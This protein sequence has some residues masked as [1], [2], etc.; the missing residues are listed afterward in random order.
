MN[1]YFDALEIELRGAV[2]R[3]ARRRLRLSVSV[4]RPQG[5]GLA[6][7]VAVPVVVA[8]LAFGLL[9]HRS[10]PAVGPLSGG[11]APAPSTAAARAPVGLVLRG[12]GL[13]EVRFGA[14]RQQVVA[15]LR[16]RL[17]RPTALRLVGNCGVDQTVYWP[18]A[19]TRHGDPKRDEIVSVDLAHGRFVGYQVGG[20]FLG[21]RKAPPIHTFR[22]TAAR[23]LTTAR[24]LALNDRLRRAR[25]LYGRRLHLSNAQ[26]GSWSVRTAHG[27]LDGFAAV[28]RF[29]IGLNAL[30]V[31][32][33]AGHVGCAAAT[34]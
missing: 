22:V 26:G 29:P 13:G 2:P 34:P 1:D 6:L 18:I 16:P 10:S 3:A 25:H 19:L 14:T 28:T 24:G 17:G 8:A 11:P 33:D 12:D 20:K 23:S 7:A 32:I 9:G 15:V 30:V 27:L 31:T 21:V 5:L 4:P